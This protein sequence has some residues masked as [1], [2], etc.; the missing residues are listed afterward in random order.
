[1]LGLAWMWWAALSKKSLLTISPNAAPKASPAMT[2]TTNTQETIALPAK[3]DREHLEA[4]ARD[5]FA[6]ILPPAPKL[7]AS[8][9]LPPAP[10]MAV[11]PPV[12]QAAPAPSPPP[13]NWRCLGQATRPDGERIIYAS[14]GDTPMLLTKGASLPNGYQVTSIEP[15]LVNLIYTP[16]NFSAQFTL[17]E[18]PQYE[19]R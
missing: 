13:L 15:K 5:P 3:I 8:K 16:L 4:S 14:L 9:K 11:A 18:P 10:V 19:I 12:L 1:M 6:F 17:P 7:P 2:Q